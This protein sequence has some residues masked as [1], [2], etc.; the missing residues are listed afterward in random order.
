VPDVILVDFQLDHEDGFE[1]IEALDH[2]WEDVVP[3]ILM[4]ADRRQDVRAR[5][6]EQGVGFLQKPIS[7][8]ILRRALEGIL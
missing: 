7:E 2:C 3:A 6:E 8:A 4:T 1:V 5:A